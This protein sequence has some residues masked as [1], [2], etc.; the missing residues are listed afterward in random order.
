MREDNDRDKLVDQR[1][2]WAESR[3]SALGKWEKVRTTLETDEKAAL[4][5]LEAAQRKARELVSAAMESWQDISAKRQRAQQERDAVVG[6]AEA[7]LRATAS[8]KI[9]D[10]VDRL[11]KKRRRN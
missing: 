5:N 9:R 10:L 1:R 11:E 3:A 4:E 7:E 2:Q 6:P 8:P